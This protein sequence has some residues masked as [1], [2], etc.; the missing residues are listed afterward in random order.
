MIEG[1]HSY[2]YEGIYSLFSPST[3]NCDQ[4]KF[5]NHYCSRFLFR[6]QTFLFQESTVCAVL[7]FLSMDTDREGF[8]IKY[9]ILASTRARLLI[10]QDKPSRSWMRVK[11]TRS[12]KLILSDCFTFLF[13][14]GGDSLTIPRNKSFVGPQRDQARAALLDS[15]F[16]IRVSIVFSTVI[17][18]S[19][20]HEADRALSSS[21]DL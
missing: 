17:F 10:L 8:L 9:I 13:F 15:N 3:T 1:G 11:P 18:L 21:R 7:F 2:L 12:K 4:R 14:L 6:V 16:L 20:G 19:D 5:M